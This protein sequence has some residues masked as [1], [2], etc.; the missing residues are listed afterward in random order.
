MKIL[1]KED[2]EVRAASV[3]KPINMIVHNM[4]KQCFFSN[5]CFRPNEAR[6]VYACVII[7]GLAFDFVQ[8]NSRAYF[9]H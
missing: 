8:T 2:I 7:G 4:K 5:K 1:D 9:I 3:L 6:N